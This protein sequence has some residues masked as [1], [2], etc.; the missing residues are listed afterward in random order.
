MLK[1]K[2]FIQNLIQEIRCKITWPTYDTLQASAVVVLVASLLFGL[3][4]GLM[5]WSL[6]KAFVWLYN[7]F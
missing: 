7:A 2:I 6:K 4:I 3:L 5:D 1:A